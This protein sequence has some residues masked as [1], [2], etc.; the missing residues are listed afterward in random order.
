MNENKCTF[1]EK[2]IPSDAV[3]CPYCNKNLKECEAIEEEPFNEE[4]NDKTEIDQETIIEEELEKKYYQYV[5]T[6]GK[7]WSQTEEGAKW[8][9]SEEGLLWLKTRT[10]RNWLDEKHGWKWL[11]TEDG[12]KWLKSNDGV[13]WLESEVDYSGSWIKT[14]R[15]KKWLKSDNGIVFTRE[16]IQNS[17]P[18]TFY[19]WLKGEKG[20]KWL[21]S[22]EGKNWMGSKSC[23]KWEKKYISYHRDWEDDFLGIAFIIGL[24]AVF[25]LFVFFG[26]WETE[27][28]VLVRNYTFAA[29]EVWWIKCFLVIFGFIACALVFIIYVF[30]LGLCIYFISFLL[31]ILIR[32]MLFRFV[33]RPIR[34]KR[35]EKLF[36]ERNEEVK[37]IK[38]NEDVD[39]EDYDEYGNQIECFVQSKGRRWLSTGVGLKWLVSDKGAQWLKTWPGRKW[40]LERRQGRK[41]LHTE[42]GAKWL[43]SNNG[44]SWLCWCADYYLLSDSFLKIIWKKIWFKDYGAEWLKSD[45]GIMWLKYEVEKLRKKDKKKESWLLTREGKKWLMT[46]DGINFIKDNTLYYECPVEWYKWLSGKE[47]RKW[48]ETEEGKNWMGGKSWEEWNNN[49]TYYWSNYYDSHVKKKIICL[50]G[51]ICAIICLSRPLSSYL[52]IH[53]D[54]PETWWLCLLQN[55]NTIFKLIV[56]AGVVWLITYVILSIMTYFARLVIRAIR[57]RKGKGLVEKNYYLY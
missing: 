56:L 6:K 32:P 57:M 7:K 28:F 36:M 26:L 49:L 5:L 52:P 45:D 46:D 31:Q 15:G 51:V 29:V 17:L 55:V 8:I 12:V 23:K 13:K 25:V 19:K 33:I 16:N 47:G 44:I 40:L 54:N 1:C 35:C 18:K 2:E 50:S 37:N 53:L 22:E 10:G 21:A 27:P 20:G 3:Y 9:G 4:Q 38:E 42:D 24:I 30:A 41:W 39:N 48:L 11:E 14:R 34:M 43:K